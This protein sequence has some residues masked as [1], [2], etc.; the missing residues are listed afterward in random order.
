MTPRRYHLYILF[1][2]FHIYQR[3]ARP[4]E[5]ALTTIWRKGE[6]RQKMVPRQA[7]GNVGQIS[8]GVRMSVVPA[9]L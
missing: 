1:K 6:F 4:S 7:L 8:E 5:I 9:A 3:N 2:R